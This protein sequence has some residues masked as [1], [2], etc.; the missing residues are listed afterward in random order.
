MLEFLK[1]TKLLSSTKK[2]TIPA[3][4]MDG[5]TTAASSHSKATLLNAPLLTMGNTHV[6][7]N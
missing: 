3:T 7:A 6:W 1:S 4:L 5:T 2:T